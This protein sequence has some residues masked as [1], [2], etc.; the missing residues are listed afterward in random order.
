LADL[1]ELA[2]YYFD[3]RK[4]REFLK[5]GQTPW[6]PPVS[7][8]F[9]LD[10]GLDR[11]NAEGPANVWARHSRYTRAIHAAVEAIGLRVF[12]QPGVH[13]VTVTA[14]NLPSSV[15]GN[16]VRKNLHAR[17]V[18]IGGGQGKLV[19][20]IIRI[21]TMGDLSPAD[22]TG[23]LGA[24]ELEL[25]SAGLKVPIGAGVE[26]AGRVLAETALAV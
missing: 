11:Y 13:S 15:D 20:K 12:S 1:Q 14:I 22:V 25:Q 26:A 5:I 19:G 10:V 21:G 4:A 23:M 6:T 18:V 8:A 2:R 16:A 7:V 9:A 3:L 24:L 17:G